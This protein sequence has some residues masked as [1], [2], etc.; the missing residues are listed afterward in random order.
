MPL[1]QE[2]IIMTKIIVEGPY[3]ED[4]V[5]GESL[6]PAP[7]VTL[8]EGHAV[9]HQ[10][11][12]ADRLR[13][14][15]DHELCK[16]VTGSTRALVN[17]SM[18]INM[19][20]GQT[21]YATQNVIGNLFYRGLVMKR[22]VYV[23]DTLY[24]STKVVLLKQNSTKKGR[25]ASGLVVLEIRVLNQNNDEILHF[26]RCPMVPCRDQSSVTGHADDLSSIPAEISDDVL[27]ESIPKW[28][29]QLYKDK[30]QGL[31]FDELEIGSHFI[32]DARDT[33]SS[34]PELVRLTLNLATTHTNAAA[35]VYGQ[36]LV[37]GGHTISMAS[38]Q[39]LRALPNIVT[40]LAWRHCDHLAAV[41]ENDRLHTEVIVNNK[42]SVSGG[43]I[44]D[45]HVKVFAERSETAPESVKNSQVLDWGVVVFMT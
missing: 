38:A 14:P 11:L 44:I 6:E 10:M 20:I 23:G 37:Y 21:T 28:D 13:L 1:F 7:S 42:I 18:V 32:I 24:T 41:F 45:L 17:P 2:Q 19:A 33:V 40:V 8:T 43:G 5:K 25:P 39:I 34:A 30:I 31:H 9:A 35:S 3:F 15:L 27:L 36:R 16:Q 4:F 12:F 29:F 22:P 26:W